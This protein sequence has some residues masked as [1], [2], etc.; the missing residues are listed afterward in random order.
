MAD[1][2][3]LVKSLFK[4]IEPQ[5]RDNIR[6]IITAS[7]AAMGFGGQ[8]NETGHPAYLVTEIVFGSLA[9]YY[10]FRNRQKVC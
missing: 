10:A 1:L 7:A 2:G 6:I 4:P 8:Y 5:Y 3:R 9:I